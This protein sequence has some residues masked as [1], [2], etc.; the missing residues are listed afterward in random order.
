MA[1]PLSYQDGDPAHVRLKEVGG[2]PGSDSFQWKIE[3]WDYQDGSHARERPGYLVMEDGSHT[4]GGMGMEAGKIATDDGWQTVSFDQSFGG[5]SSPVVLTTV[6]TYNGGDPVVTRVKNVTS[7]GFEV[8]VQEEEALGSHTTETIGY[9]AIEVGEV[10]SSST[11]LTAGQTAEVVE[12]FGGGEDDEPLWHGISLP[13]GPGY[14]SYVVLANQ[15]T[16]NGGDTA[17]LRRRGAVGRQVDLKYWNILK[18][19]GEV[20]ERKTEGGGSQYYMKDHLGSIRVV[21]DGGD[22]FVEE[23]DYYTD[24]CRCCRCRVATRRGPLRQR[25]T[26]PGT[27]RTRPLGCTTPGLGT[28]QVRS[29]G[30]RRRI[31][32]SGRKGRKPC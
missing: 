31:R 17:G 3:E 15:Q 18:P 7:E 27:S 23:R 8:R 16:A 11:Q 25:R 1:G 28:T 26:L 6:Q 24:S 21:I 29:G 20:I 2:G 13:T 14:Q 19:G 12:G 22:N 4:I 32:F 30:G 9:V 5:R 10:S